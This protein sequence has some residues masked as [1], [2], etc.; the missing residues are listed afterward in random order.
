[1]TNVR[2]GVPETQ[3]VNFWGNLNAKVSQKKFFFFLELG[4]FL[5]AIVRTCLKGLSLKS[6]NCPTVPYIPSKS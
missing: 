3:Q 6:E 4:W 1:M 2:T 5:K